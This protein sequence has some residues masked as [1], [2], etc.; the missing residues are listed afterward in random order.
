MKRPKQNASIKWARTPKIRRVI[1][2]AGLK[3]WIAYNFQRELNA[4][5]DRIVKSEYD[6]WDYMLTGNTDKID[7]IFEIEK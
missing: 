3:K 5:N 7:K 1:A 6:F 4:L 2:I